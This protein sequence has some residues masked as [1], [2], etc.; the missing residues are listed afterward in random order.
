MRSALRDGVSVTK[1]ADVAGLLLTHG[2]RRCRCVSF[3]R[4]VT[5]IQYNN[6]THVSRAGSGSGSGGGGNGGVV[7]DSDGGRAG[8]GSGSDGGRAGSGGGAGGSGVVVVDI[9]LIGV[10]VVVEVV[11]VIVGLVW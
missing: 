9:V 5:D 7:G 10:L 3:V 8:S 11:V 2:I 1:N 6:V 4:E